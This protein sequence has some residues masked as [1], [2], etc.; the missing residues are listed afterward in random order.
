MNRLFG[1]LLLAG[2]AQQVDAQ[3]VLNLDSCRALALR[4]NKQLGVSRVTQDIAKNLRKSAR[5]K[6]LPHVSALGGYEYTS[7]EVSLLSNDQKEKLSNLGTTVTDAVKGKL[8]EVMA[9][10]PLTSWP[11]ISSLTGQTPAGIQ[12]GLTDGLAKVG[13]LEHGRPLHQRWLQPR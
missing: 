11:T 9:D 2:F 3:R 6:Y 5:T 7:K 8:T 10:I 12:Q 1:F 13:G 4:N